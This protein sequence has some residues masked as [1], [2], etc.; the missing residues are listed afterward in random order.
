MKQKEYRIADRLPE[1]LNRDNMRELAEVID[2][3]MAEINRMSELVSIYPRIDELSP[4][5]IDALA[6]QLHIDFYDTKLPLNTRRAL[7][8]NSVKW[9]MRKGTAAV[10]RELI[11]TIW[12]SGIV[13][14]WY[15]YQ[16]LTQIQWHP[17][18]RCGSSSASSLCYLAGTDHGNKRHNV[19]YL[20]NS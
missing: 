15:E 11:N 6:I 7:V 8:E 3:K 5:L 19:R 16:L 14:E 2:E 13:R 9:H 1:S 10:V 4:N 20:R 17:V 18:L 12:D